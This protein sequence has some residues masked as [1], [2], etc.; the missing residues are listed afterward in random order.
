M[1]KVSPSEGKYFYKKGQ[2][3]RKKILRR[4]NEWKRE[5]KRGEKDDIFNSSNLGMRK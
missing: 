2:G 5:R 4:N 3:F 1:Q